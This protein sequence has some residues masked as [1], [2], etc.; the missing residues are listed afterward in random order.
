MLIVVHQLSLTLLFLHTH[1]P[2]DCLTGA[3][4]NLEA[5]R[6]INIAKYMKQCIY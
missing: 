1:S 2:H 4:T 6:H 3:N 5:P